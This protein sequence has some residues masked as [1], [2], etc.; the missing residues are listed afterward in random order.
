MKRITEVTPTQKYSTPNIDNLLNAMPATGM[1]TFEDQIKVSATLG[2]YFDGTDYSGESMRKISALTKR[3]DA[4]VP[5]ELGIE[6]MDDEDSDRFGFKYQ[7]S[8]FWLS[9]P[10][11]RNMPKRGNNIP[12][13]YRDLI[14]RLA[15]NSEAIYELPYYV[16][17][18]LSEVLGK[19]LGIS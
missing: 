5:K 14:D 10:S 13:Y 3:M 7:G 15:E 9:S 1:D 16:F 11:I 18:A 12:N 8:E 2:F 6:F 17:G 19:C 4:E